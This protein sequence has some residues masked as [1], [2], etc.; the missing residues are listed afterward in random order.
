MK[1]KMCGSGRNGAVY[2][3]GF[4]GALVYY[5]GTA[6]TFWIGVLGII[7]AMVWPAMLVHA[8]LKYLN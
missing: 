8:A 3:L 7:K 1:E 2:G 4:V 6:T 5:L